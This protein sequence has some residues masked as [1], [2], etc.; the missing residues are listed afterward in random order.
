MQS[1]HF[2]FFSFHF[3]PTGIHF[4]PVLKKKWNKEWKTGRKSRCE[5]SAPAMRAPFTL[6][7]GLSLRG[8]QPD[9]AAA[10][11]RGSLG[12]LTSE[13]APRVPPTCS[14]VSSCVKL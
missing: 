2:I 5:K 14:P 6:R 3:M 7:D 9:R 12:V 1:E 11:G 8:K 10:N 13:S 4:C